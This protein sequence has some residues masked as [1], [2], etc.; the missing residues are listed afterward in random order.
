MIIITTTKETLSN[1]PLN[2]KIMKLYIF[3]LVI[4]SILSLNS[5]SGNAEEYGKQPLNLDKFNFDLN[6]E[7]FF[8]NEDIFRGK[9]DY[10][11]RVEE[12]W[13]S[14]DSIEMGYIDYATV[15]MSQDRPLAKYAGVEFE[16]LGI[17]T[18]WEDE[19][20]IMAYASTDYATPK[21]VESILD[22]LIKDYGNPEM[23]SQGFGNEGLNL[24]FTKDSKVATISLPIPYQAPEP[25]IN[26]SENYYDEAPSE[27]EKIYLTDEIYAEI[28]E[29]M[30]NMEEIKCYLFITNLTFDNALQEASS[31]SGD[32]THY[33]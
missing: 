14:G 29:S 16:S 8:Q 3:F 26:Y 1:N 9:A 19:K 30:K 27:P 17:I 22:K 24:K 32:L 18:D 21:N 5:C 10:A 13:I 11:M 23:H 4:I 31:F 6:I 33:R 12:E 28:K 2:F 15:S 25:E 7:K 20:A